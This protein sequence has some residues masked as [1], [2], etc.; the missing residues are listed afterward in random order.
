M[1][2]SRA[3]KD[4]IVEMVQAI[5]TADACSPVV[6]GTRYSGADVDLWAIFARVSDE[7]F[8]IG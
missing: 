8:G 2:F 7:E 4:P 3:S 1:L 6:Q 5:I